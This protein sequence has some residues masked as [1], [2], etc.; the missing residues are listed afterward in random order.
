LYRSMGRLQD[1][2][3]CIRK[4]LELNP[5]RISGHHLVAILLADQGR[6]GEALAEANLEPAEWARLTG[7][8]YVHHLAGRKQ[9]SDEALRRL[10]ETYSTESAYQIAATHSARGEIDAG[11]T[12]LERAY[13]ERDS[14]LSQVKSEPTFRRLHA[15]PRWGALLTKM[16]LQG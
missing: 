14:G 16:G 12:W 7:L 2:E 13:A 10:E 1:A 3:R 9:E 11:L 15:D 8:A 4:G 6:L 5:Q